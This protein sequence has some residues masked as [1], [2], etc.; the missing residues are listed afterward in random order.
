M[1]GKKILQSKLFY[2]VSLDRLIP[3]DHQV[4]RIAEALDLKFL[5]EETKEYYSHEGKPS[6][7]PVV[8]FKLYILA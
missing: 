5:Y 8:L 1:E 4:R 6:I 7:D 2:N 3:Q